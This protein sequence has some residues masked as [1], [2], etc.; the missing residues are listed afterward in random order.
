LSKEEQ[1]GASDQRFWETVQESTRPSDYEAYLEAFPNGLFAS[2]AR[3][4]AQSLKVQQ[5]ARLQQPSSSGF[6][7]PD[8]S[9]VSVSP[10][11]AVAFQDYIDNHGEKL[12]V[13]L[14]DLLSHDPRFTFERGNPFCEL[15]TKKNSNVVG[16]YAKGVV[17]SIEIEAPSIEPYRKKPACLRRSYKQH[18]LA[19]WD[20]VSVQILGVLDRD[21]LEELGIK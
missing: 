8:N 20:G 15:E 4:R 3:N 2:L 19:N 17:V 18:V 21:A 6:T 9:L 12:S 11:E 5:V 10:D 16:R 13:R 7:V 1:S 14:M